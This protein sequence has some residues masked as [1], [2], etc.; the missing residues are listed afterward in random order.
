MKTINID[1]KEYVL[2]ADVEKELEKVKQKDTKFHVVKPYGLCDDN[3]VIAMGTA[4][5]DSNTKAVM[6]GYDYL[7][8]AAKI[9]KE[10]GCEYVT[11]AIVSEETPLIIGHE[12]D[13]K[14]RLSGLL[15]APRIKND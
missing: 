7:I 8:C 15:I 9:L 3:H 12:I 4:Q 14:N 13:E 6:I 10:I 1:G 11:I 5:L 2:K